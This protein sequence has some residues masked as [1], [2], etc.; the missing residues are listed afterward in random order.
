MGESRG[1][2]VVVGKGAH[3]GVLGGVYFVAGFFIVGKFANKR[4]DGGN[5]CI[6]AVSMF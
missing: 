5:I 3:E 2:R 4:E 6:V 1:C